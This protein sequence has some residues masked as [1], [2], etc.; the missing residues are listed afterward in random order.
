MFPY[1]ESTL[2]KGEKIIFG[3]RPH[4]IIYMPAVLTLVISF[5]LFTYGPD[6]TVLLSK[7]YQNYR[8]YE[9][10]SAATLIIGAYSMLKAFLTHKT[11]EYVITS[12]RIVMKTGWIRRNA[13]EVFLRR[14]E[15]VNVSQTVPGRIFGYGTVAVMGVGGTRDFFTN[16]PN[17][18][19]FRSRV[20]QELDGCSEEK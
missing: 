7:V 11:S 12:Q 13:L 2:L 16:V 9:I 19:H 8:L 18:L 5:F 10:L 4:W 20:Q 14:L 6:Y 17:P 3:A 1:V 15:A